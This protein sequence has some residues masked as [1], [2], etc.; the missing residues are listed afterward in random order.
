M[1]TR[2]WIF[3]RAGSFLAEGDKKTAKEYFRKA[4]A[5]EDSLMVADFN[6]VA[7][8]LAEK[9]FD[10]TSRLL[11]V[12]REKFP[13]RMPNVTRIPLYAQYVKSPQ[14]QAWLKTAKQ[15]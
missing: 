13:K 3:L 2:I 11:T 14:Y 8:S 4:V 1:A 10:E 15:P 6:L 5:A 7:I 12:I 9:D